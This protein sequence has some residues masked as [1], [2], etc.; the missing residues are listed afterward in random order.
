M[1]LLVVGPNLTIDRTSTLAA[2]RPGEVLRTRDVRV[3]PGGKGVN[4][5]RAATALGASASLI[6]FLPGRLGGVA[7]QMLA[8]EGVALRGVACD[9]ELRSTSILISDDGRVTVINEPGPPVTAAQWSALEDE[10][11]AGLHGADLL[12]CSGSVPPGAPADAVARLVLLARTARVQVVV[13][14]SS[15]RLGPAV[16]AGPDLVTPNL[17]E[18]EALLGGAGGRTQARAFAAAEALVKLG[19]GA[20]VV[21]AG[22]AGAALAGPGEPVWLPAPRVTVR[23]PIGAGDACTAGLAVGLLRGLPLAAA[24]ALGVAAASASVE[25]WLAGDVDPRRVAELGQLDQLEHRRLQL[26]D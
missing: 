24:A 5:V 9:G 15:A 11:T 25:S 18:A 19:A 2:L 22:A 7:A 20:A 6:G 17:A 8:D 3:T 23:N 26:P 13:D 16:T 12:V 1:V 21:T 14:T 4:V 10:V